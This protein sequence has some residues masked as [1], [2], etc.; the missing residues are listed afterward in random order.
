[1]CLGNISK[2]FSANYKKETEWNGYV[3]GFSV[4]CFSINVNAM[5]D[6]NVWV[7]LKNYYCFNEHSY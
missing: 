7:Y 6:V 5:P 2:Y 3:Y 1:M 4:D